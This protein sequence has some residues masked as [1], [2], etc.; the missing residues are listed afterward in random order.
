MKRSLAAVLAADVAGYSKLLGEDTEQT[1]T[2]LRRLRTEVF[3]PTVASRRGRVVKSMGDGWI[4]LF[5]AA[6]DAANCA[7][8]IQDLLSKNAS[9]QVPNM[10][11]RLGVHLGDVV[12]EEEDVFGDGVNVAA[13]LEQMAAPGSIAISDAVFGSLD[14]TLRPSFDDAG[15]RELKN[16]SRPVRVWTRGS[17]PGQKAP[18][19]SASQR[20]QIVV[21]P[22]ETS[23]P[24]DEVRE[25]SDALT[26]DLMTYLGATHW[27][28]VT[29]TES[30]RR[31]YVLSGRIRASGNRLRLEIKYIDPDGVEL[32]ST[33]IDG[34]MDN[35]FDWQDETAESLISQV[36]TATF[37]SERLQ[38]DKLAIEDMT[39][40]QCELRG[41]LAI[42][43]LDPDA[44]ASALEYSSVAIRKDPSLPH[45]HALALVSFLSATVMGY[46][47]VARKYAKS[48][49][50]WCS[51]AAPLAENNSLLR[52][53][54][55]VTTYSQ[56]REPA[57]LRSTVEY[58][59]RQCSSDFITLALSGWAYV[60][61][62]DNIA[63]IDCFKKATVLGGY[64]PWA[65]SIRGGLAMA[66]LQA[67]NDEAAIKLAKD[68]LNLSAGYATLYRVLAAA[69]AQLGRQ[70]EASDAL[71]AAL[72]LHPN[73]NVTSILARNVFAVEGER[74]RY[75]SG[76]RKAGM[77]E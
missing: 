15:E 76:L 11:L 71:N 19:S 66:T 72:R 9:H 10:Q 33:K 21:R 51:A 18:D 75:I 48:V 68:G 61:I 43:R 31:S 65:L 60:W 59:L 38:L 45:P 50:S 47:N 55:G 3:S 6:S 22:I 42:D 27:L 41:Q 39:A 73:D 17:L 28:S 64:S 46:E 7:L 69:Q 62:G 74:N 13:R 1:L 54:L 30:A 36:M 35:A 57:I 23:D 14:G 5:G 32:W 37:D 20:P 2:S 77:K 12:E 56:H 53:A 70:D 52:L 49:P 16:I 24:R 29:A 40:N 67:G 25:L 4:V 8:Q 44:F 26:G 34:D 63:A 58:A